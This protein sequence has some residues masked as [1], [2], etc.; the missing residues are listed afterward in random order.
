MKDELAKKISDK[1]DAD[2][3]AA[4]FENET[5]NMLRDYDNRLRQNGLDLSTYCKYTGMTLESLREQMRPQAEQQV[6]VRLALEAIAAAEGIEA[7]EEDVNGEYQYI[8]DTYHVDIEEVKKS[9]DAKDI[10]EDVKVKK[11]MDFVVSKA[12]IVD[13]APEEAKT[14]TPE[15]TKDAE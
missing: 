1:L 5:E 6:K 12:Q 10:A 2:I 4:M 3:P 14:E 9:I 13:A 11:A 15:E 8:A 7:T